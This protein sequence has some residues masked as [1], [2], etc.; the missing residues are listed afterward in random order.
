MTKQQLAEQLF[1]V[2]FGHNATQQYVQTR[3]SSER[4]MLAE[5]INS[6]LVGEDRE[7]ALHAEASVPWAALKDKITAEAETVIVGSFVKDPQFSEQDLRDLV[8]FFSSTLGQR[9]IK[10]RLVQTALMDPIIRRHM[11]EAQQVMLRN[12]VKGELFEV[13][14]VPLGKEGEE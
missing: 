1:K 11:L 12:L 9:Y 10:A 7:K 2:M 5:G 4:D 3:L 14:K 8:T 6:K 13:Q